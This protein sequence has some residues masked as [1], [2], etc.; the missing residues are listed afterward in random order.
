M[1][2]EQKILLVYIRQRQIGCPDAK[3]A[4]VPELNY[5]QSLDVL[6]GSSDLWISVDGVRYIPDTVVKYL[7]VHKDGSPKTLHDF[8]EFIAK[9]KIAV[10]DRFGIQ[11]RAAKEKQRFQYWDEAFVTALFAT[12][13]MD[14]ES[15][16]PRKNKITYQIR[17]HTSHKAL[18][19]LKNAADTIIVEKVFGPKKHGNIFRNVQR[20]VR[21]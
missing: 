14:N 17:P 18:L 16:D 5:V 12:I 20:R 8:S 3:P 6:F 15:P 19:H 13:K 10:S 2:P 9:R 21:P 7:I 4:R 1:R 11:L